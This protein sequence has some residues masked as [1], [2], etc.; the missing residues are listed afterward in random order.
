MKWVETLLRTRNRVQL[1]LDGALI[2]SL[3]PLLTYSS[4]WFWRY[5][6]GIISERSSGKEREREMWRAMRRTK[7]SSRDE[8][9]ARQSDATGSTK[10]YL[11]NAAR[12]VKWSPWAMRSKRYIVSCVKEKSPQRAKADHSY[13]LS[14]KAQS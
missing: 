3:F 14:G 5:I 10:E 7:M 13:Q 1:H 4:W 11:Q 9:H 12:R 6:R 2:R 8:Q